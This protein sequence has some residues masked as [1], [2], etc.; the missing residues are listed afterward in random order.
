MTLSASW[1]LDYLKI[2][3]FVKEISAGYPHHE[4]L[5]RDF[6]IRAIPY[7]VPLVVQLLA[8]QDTALIVLFR[9]RRVGSTSNSV[10][11]V[12]QLAEFAPARVLVGF[13]R[14]REL[15]PLQPESKPVHGSTL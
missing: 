15:F 6:V 11:R 1:Q 5:N 9:I 12:L 4:L 8:W 14:I 13:C 7:P 3:S 10:V 2:P